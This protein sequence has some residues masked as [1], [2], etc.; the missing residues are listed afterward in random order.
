MAAAA[1]A[2]QTL[3]VG[4]QPARRAPSQSAC[5][6]NGCPEPLGTGYSTKYRICRQH[7]NATSV[8]LSEGTFGRFCQQCSKFHPL[9]EFEGEKLSCRAGLERHTQ[10]RKERQAR[11]RQA[12]LQRGGAVAAVVAAGSKR[13]AG[14]D[15]SDTLRTLSSSPCSS[16][17]ATQSWERRAR[18]RLGSAELLPLPTPLPSAPFAQMSAAHSLSALTAFSQLPS[19]P[20]PAAAQQAWTP[21]AS[22]FDLPPLPQPP[23]DPSLLLLSNAAA[24]QR[25]PTPPPMPLPLREGQVD[26][27][28]EEET[29][30]ASE[31]SCKASP[32]AANQASA[33]NSAGQPC[34]P[35][36]VAP[37]SSTS[38]AT[39]SLAR[40]SSDDRS[41]QHPPS[42]T[43]SRQRSTPAM[44]LAALAAAPLPDLSD[45]ATLAVPGHDAL[46]ALPSLMAAQQQSLATAEQQQQ[47]QQQSPAALLPLL[48]GAVALL[49][50]VLQIAKPALA[51]QHAANH[52]ARSSAAPHAPAAPPASPFA[53]LAGLAS[54]AAP[55]ACSTAPDLA[56]LASLAAP[57]AC[58]TAP[59]LAALASLVPPSAPSASA[60]T[61]SLSQLRQLAAARL[62][63]ENKKQV[64][65][66]LQNEHSLMQL[67]AMMQR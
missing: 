64:Q 48:Q 14:S 15:G 57:A 60:A 26:A 21:L 51:A 16:S 17:R 20:L 38:T 49:Q 41:P 39:V 6:V 10:R 30:G 53:G 52:R 42:A 27:E 47:Q 1:E 36:R 45:L 43:D 62:A 63:E 3:S 5:R 9:S 23:L 50:G 18:A 40:Q 67:L 54:L 12:L 59:D 34:T 29:D 32:A 56:G 31:A 13:G 2:A 28:A 37:T 11:Q 66:S 19:T 35:D 7:Y 61:A 4:T 33:G 46:A 65:Q 8:E 24:A 55:A 22:L 58:S 25:C 44:A